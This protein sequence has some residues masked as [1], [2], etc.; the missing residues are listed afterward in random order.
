MSLARGFIAQGA[1]T[2]WP[3]CGQSRTG[4]L[5]ISWHCLC[6]LVDRGSVTE[7]LRAA[8]QAL[9]SRPQYRDP[10][11]WAPYVLY[12]VEATGQMKFSQNARE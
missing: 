7:A 2:C 12:T 6:E 11:F 4:H 3:L 5:P 9:R 10:F 1:R 8:Q